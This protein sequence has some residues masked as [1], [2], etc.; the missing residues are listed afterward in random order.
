MVNE[1]YLMEFTDLLDVELVGD[2][3]Q[4]FQNDCDT[5]WEGMHELPTEGVAEALYKKQLEK[6]V[7]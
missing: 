3:V 4:A 5:V 2:N 1:F 6:S 7:A